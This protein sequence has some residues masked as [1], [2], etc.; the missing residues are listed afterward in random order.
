MECTPI[1]GETEYPPIYAISSPV[2]PGMH[3]DMP[4]KMHYYI[5]KIS[6]TVLKWFMNLGFRENVKLV[7][8]R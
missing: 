4:L 7:V 2:L 6:P 1:I 8:S 3:I 5:L